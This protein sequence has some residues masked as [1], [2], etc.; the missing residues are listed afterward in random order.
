MLLSIEDLSVRY[1][2]SGAHDAKVAVR[3]FDLRLRQGESYALL[4]PSG[5]GKS[6]VG[7]AALGLLPPSAQATGRVRVDDVDLLTTSDA[8]L[9]QRRGWRI[10]HVG[11]SPAAALN[12]SLRIG[13]QVSEAV[14]IRQRWS[15]RVARDFAAARLAEVGLDAPTA[16]AWPHELS[17]GQMRRVVL[18]M[19]LAT[20]PALLI[21]DEPTSSLDTLRRVEI[22]VLLARLV[23]ARGLALLLITHDVGAAVALCE[24]FGVLAD[25]QLIEQGATRPFR[26]LHPYTALLA[27]SALGEP[28]DGDFRDAAP[29]VP[30]DDRSS[31]PSFRRVHRGC[32]YRALC[33]RAEP[34]CGMHTPPWN[35]RVR[36]FVVPDGREREAPADAED[37]GAPSGEQ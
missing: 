1:G 8:A 29:V 16:D 6:T 12:P 33:D 10:A 23:K 13:I 7:L 35:G 20:D 11:Q 4:G 21:A 37:G 17:V 15:R 32:G 9:D 2:S 14:A 24:R 22:S 28:E 25:G 30:A 5:A 36:C 34:R 19:A 31:S 3:R 27:S 18:A 26:P